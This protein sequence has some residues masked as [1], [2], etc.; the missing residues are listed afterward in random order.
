LQPA[1]SRSVLLLISRQMSDASQLLSEAARR[2]PPLSA[3]SHKGQA[4]RLCVVG[5][6]RE[7]TGAPY[8]AAAAALRVGADLAHV[9]CAEAAAPVIKSYSPELIVHPVL[10]GESASRE[11]ELWLPRFHAVLVGPGLGRGECVAGAEADGLAVVC[12]RPHLISGAGRVLLTP[13]IV[14]LGRLRSALC[15]GDSPDTDE[16]AEST[17]RRISRSLGGGVAL[18]CK[19]PVDVAV[20]DNDDGNAA[21]SSTLTC[22]VVGSPRRCGGQGDVLAGLA[23]AFANWCY[24]GPASPASPHPALLAAFAASALTRRCSAAAFKVNRR[25]MLASDL[26][27]QIGPCSRELFP[28][29]TL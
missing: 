19:G 28:R 1:L 15:D 17:A 10:D 3:G 21:A 2:I 5:G 18:L 7:Y 16:A 4:G 20:I 12:S 22:S 11:L 23:L 25:A 29:L 27:A 26:L 9:I 24:A 14:E 8:F 13:N 6:C